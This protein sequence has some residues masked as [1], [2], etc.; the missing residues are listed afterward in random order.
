MAERPLVARLKRT[1]APRAMRIAASIA[2]GAMVAV[3]FPPFDWWLCT[4]VAFGLLAWV[5][6]HPSTT[7]AGGFGYGFLFGLAF[8]VPLLP[9]ISGFVGS[10]PWLAL[11]AMEALFPAVFGLLAVVV[12][13]LPG[14]PAWFA[15]L[16][17]LAEWL[18]STIPFGGF[19]WGVVGYTQDNS[20]L[21]VIAHFGGVPLVSFAV[22]LVGFGLGALTMEAVRW[23]RTDHHSGR[24]DI[25][26]VVV[27]G[28]SVALVLVVVALATPY[29]KQSSAGAGDD[30]PTT[31][32]A[33]QGSV[34]RLG[35]D[36]N[37]Q[38]R[39]VLDNHVRQTL[40][41]AED[42]RAG[43]APQ[44]AVVI[45]PEN[46]S[47]I[48]PIVNKDAADQ[49]GVA[50]DA[51]GAPILVGA[52]VAAPG[53]TPEDP[54]ATNTVIAWD[55]TTGP[56]ERHDKKIVQPF[57]EYLPWRSFFRLL[58]SFADRAGYF[59]PGD[60][61]GVV[62]AA[63]IPIGVTTCWEVIFDRAARESVLNGA[64]FIA[65]PTNNA[66]FDES[67][68]AQLLSF[69]RL[70]AV[71]HDRFVV[72]AGT[73]GISAVIGPDGR[74]LARSEWF[75]PAYLDAQIRL[76]TSL[77]PATRWGPAIQGLIVIAGAAGLLWAMLHNGAFAEKFARRRQKV[78]ERGEAEDE[79][80]A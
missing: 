13:K 1:L 8:Y 14:W 51:I 4:F 23:W 61:D 15:C 44:P 29:V 76:K 7:K 36:F 57:G 56:G 18:K 39:A 46:S 52:V 72:V 11:S 78:S 65:V 40:R 10:V 50:T 30:P 22:A 16:W 68:S 33:V 21:L 43:R 79:G 24:V 12:R 66:T 59:V 73:V 53:Y 19:P 25:P 31:V 2:A 54:Q 77:T 41:L 67:M 6:A 5:L 3:S 28:V 17:V 62:H 26:T 80:V 60:G 42:V 55:P 74:E 64:Q 37:A 71:E 38:R 70:R 75:E 9:W 32:A 45:W 69:A 63:G 58:S 20:P 34:P 47:D 27:P 35:L 48:D 49:I